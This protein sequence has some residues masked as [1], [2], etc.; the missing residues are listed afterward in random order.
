MV[1]AAGSRSRRVLALADQ[2]LHCSIGQASVSET[3]VRCRCANYAQIL[4][5]IFAPLNRLDDV[6]STRK[7]DRDRPRC[8]WTYEAGLIGPAFCRRARGPF[9]L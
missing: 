5:A 1:G 3:P 8:E 6:T 2:N 9:C 4:L 7:D